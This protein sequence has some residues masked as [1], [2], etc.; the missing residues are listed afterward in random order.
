MTLGTKL[1][2]LLAVTILGC[3]NSTKPAVTAGGGNGGTDAATGNGGSGP[4]GGR[5]GTGGIS[6]NKP[7]WDWVGIIGTGQSLSVG[8]NGTP[9]TQ[10][11]QPYNNLKLALGTATVP[12]YDPTS[13]ALSVVP[14]VEPIRQQATSYPSAYPRNVYG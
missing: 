2:A 10:T 12:P 6:T 14:L 3:S 8:A 4:N 1:V 13:S 7:A 5:G 11:S 9:L